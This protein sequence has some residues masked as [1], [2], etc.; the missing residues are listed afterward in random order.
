MVDNSESSHLLH[1]RLPVSGLLRAPGCY[2]VKNRIV[3]EESSI[4]I[5]EWNWWFQLRAVNKE[6]ED[7]M[8]VSE[9]SN[10]DI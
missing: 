5:L 3:D 6:V 10:V 8:L 4:A 2:V 1:I 9:E 7:K